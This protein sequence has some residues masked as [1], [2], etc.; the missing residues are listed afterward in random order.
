MVSKR[1]GR[2]WDVVC[3]RFPHD[4]ISFLRDYVDTSEDYGSVSDIIREAVWEWLA[5][6]NLDPCKFSN[7]LKECREETKR[8][9]LR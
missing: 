6:R 8:A 1:W 2:R 7:D 4:W 3:I 5:N 9:L